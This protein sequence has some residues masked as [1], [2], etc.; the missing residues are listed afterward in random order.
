MY[1]TVQVNTISSITALQVY[2][3]K[4][5]IGEVNGPPYLSQKY[6]ENRLWTNYPFGNMDK[7]MTQCTKMYSVLK[8]LG[9][10]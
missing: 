1:F 10:M 4:P 3:L 8:V 7:N 5:G 9:D 6:Y 2:Y